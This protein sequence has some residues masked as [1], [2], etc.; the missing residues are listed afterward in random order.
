M[1][2][3]YILLILASVLSSCNLYDAKH[4]KELNKLGISCME[5]GDKKCAIANF[6]QASQAGAIPDSDRT[7]YLENLGQEYSGFKL[8][9]AKYYY[10]R[11]AELNGRNTVQWLYIMAK[12]D[13]LDGH[14]DQ[15]LSRLTLAYAKDPRKMG[16]NNLLGALYMGDY[17]REYLDPHKALKYNLYCYE[18]N[19]RVRVEFLLARNYYELNDMDHALPL[20]EDA[21]KKAPQNSN[22][23]GS[24]IM[25][26]QELGMDSLANPLLEQIKARDSGTYNIIVNSRIRKGQHGL[27]WSR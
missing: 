13:L 4:A 19:K 16:V 2:S 8:D 21:E 1:R 6:L 12:M 15:A 27:V 25:V 23:K 11:A 17:G 24:L 26:Y 18:V 10:G 3:I 14:T 22:F 5:L 9:S 7:I 20:F